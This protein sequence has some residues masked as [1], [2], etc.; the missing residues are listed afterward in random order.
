MSAFGVG[1]IGLLGLVVGS[2]IW[3]VSWARATDRPLL[4]G[5]VCANPECGQPLPIIAW[6][7]FL[8]LGMART[9]AACHTAQPV[10]RIAF[11]VAVA[12]YFGLAAATAGT[13][14]RLLV[15]ILVFAVPILV[16][17]LIDTWTRFIYTDIV[18][19]GV[20]AGVIYAGLD[21]IAKGSPRYLAS[22]VVAAA[23]GVIFF[24]FLF[25][26]AA[27]VYRSVRVVPFGMGDVYLAGMIGAMLR[28]PNGPYAL[29]AGI[30]IAGVASVILLLT[31]RAGMRQAIA[32]GPYLCAGALIY[33]LRPV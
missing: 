6:L 10:R 27:V 4:S 19:V 15:A 22:S 14:P 25:V 31:R 32:Y 9:C 2:A 5:P 29:I 30:L 20:A 1:L 24:A 12:I 17:L 8:G 23:I 26:I 16:I 21:S 28:F 7:P 13:K 18:G 33:L 3:V 11:E